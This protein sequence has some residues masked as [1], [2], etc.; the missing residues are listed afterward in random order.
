[1]DYEKII[2][3][4]N[5]TWPRI[6]GQ[7][8]GF[9]SSG[10]FGILSALPDQSN[11]ATFAVSTSLFFII[12]DQYIRKMLKYIS[13]EYNE[14]KYWNYIV[15]EWLDNFYRFSIFIVVQYINFFM[16]GSLASPGNKLFVQIISVAIIILIILFLVVIFEDDKEK[17]HTSNEENEHDSVN[18]FLRAWNGLYAVFIQ[19][20]TLFFF[21]ELKTLP[22]QSEIIVSTFVTVG[23][24]LIIE[25]IIRD[26][27]KTDWF[28]SGRN[29]IIIKYIN[30]ILDFGSIFFIFFI[31]E[32]TG[33][34][35]V[36][37]Q[38]S[39]QMSV[40]GKL[41]T[42]FVVYIIV[43]SMFAL[44]THLSE[45]VSHKFIWVETIGR[46]WPR[47]Y[48]ATTGIFSKIIINYIFVPDQL[49]LI[50]LSVLVTLLLYAAF[51]S[52]LRE[53]LHETKSVKTNPEWAAVLDE[54]LDFPLTLAPLLTINVFFDKLLEEE[55]KTIP[56]LINILVISIV[57]QMIITA[58]FSLFKLIGDDMGLSS[59]EEGKRK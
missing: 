32:F 23:F 34:W 31:V 13:P 16:S 50:I 6:S 58:I 7:I 4:L 42:V 24:Y 21:N 15:D 10:V 28:T 56:S 54:L 29:P 36:N 35:I 46:I 33:S 17:V 22:N 44:I 1:M 39:N 45:S 2:L 25:S 8:T 40:Y 41:T 3:A 11:I 52:Y 51:E 53:R 38:G 37:V 14:K 12:V 18:N 48:G 30:S 26:I 49:N 47:I 27:M 59:R 57:S 5:R 55:P 9:I 19:F 43:Y 20:Y